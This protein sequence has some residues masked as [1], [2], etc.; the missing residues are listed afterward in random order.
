MTMM[1]RIGVAQECDAREV[2]WNYKSWN[3]NYYFI[4]N[5]MNE[6]NCLPVGRQAS[7]SPRK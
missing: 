1:N 2:K 7:A 5:R 4:T 6:E 3:Q